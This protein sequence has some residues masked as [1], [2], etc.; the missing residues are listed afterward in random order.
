[1]N[2]EKQQ[3]IALM[4]YDAIAPLV[5]GLDE[6]YPSKSAFYDEVSDKGIAGPDGSIHLYAPATIEN[7]YLAYQK[8]GFDALLPKGRSDA[9]MSR[10]L[11]EELQERIRYFK[12][13]YPRMSAAAIYRQLKTDGSII[14]CKR[15]RFPIIGSAL[16]QNH[17]C[18][19]LI[20][21][22]SCLDYFYQYMFAKSRFS[23]T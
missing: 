21:I 16:P 14:V 20:I 23:T 2:Q 7:W 5:A 1:M 10:K 13:S 11:D 3:K 8:H 18:Q 9:G 12:T 6:R 19:I 17:H 4:R 15:G 22:H